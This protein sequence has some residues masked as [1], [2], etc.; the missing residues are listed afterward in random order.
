MSTP[1]LR[2][3]ELLTAIAEEEARLAKLEE[4]QAAAQGRLVGLRSELAEYRAERKID[5]PLPLVADA[6]APMTSDEKVKLFQSLFRGRTDVFP[7][8]FVSKKT[9]KPGYAPACT[10]KFVQRRLRAPKGEVR[11]MHRTRRSCPVDDA[12]VVGHLK[13]QH[14]MGVYPLLEDETCWFLAVDFDKSTWTEDV[15]RLRGDMPACRTA[16]RGRALALGQRRP[17]LVLLLGARRRRPPRARWAAT[18][19]PRRWRGRHQLEHGLLRPAV[20]QPGHHAARRLR[21]PHRTAASA[22]AAA[23]GQLG[24]SRRRPRSR[25]ADDQ[26]WATSPRSTR[27][28]PSTVEQDRARSHPRGI[29]SSAFGWPKSP[30]TRT[31]RRGRGHPREL[32]KPL[33]HRRP[34]PTECRAVLAQR[35]FVEKAGAPV[36]AAQPDQAPRGLSEPGVLQEAEHAPLDSDDAA[37]DLVRRGSAAARRVFREAARSELEELLR[38]SR[39]RARGRGRAHRAVSRCDLRFQGTLTPVQGRLRVR[40]S[41]TTSACSWRR[42]GVGKTVVGTYLVA[43]RAAAR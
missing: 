39:R 18:S 10:N 3:E 29:A 30:T 41:R 6:P 36:A 24:L 14:V 37:G 4:D 13:G 32:A 17:R 8:R 20:P 5:V 25:L 1:P 40:C 2:R 33:R 42:P 16:R 21:Q 35:L 38:E 9:G 28:D 22:R 27:I 43:A 34:L 23:A 15:E 26:Q 11:R 31:R 12:A 19:S 7:T